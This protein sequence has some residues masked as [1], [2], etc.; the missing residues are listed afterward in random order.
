MAI[1]W[2]ISRYTLWKRSMRGC[3]RKKHMSA[4]EALLTMVMI[5]K[6]KEQ[7]NTGVNGEC[8]GPTWM[9]DWYDVYMRFLYIFS[10]N[11]NIYFYIRISTSYLN[12]W[13][14]VFGPNQLPMV[15]PSETPI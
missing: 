12:T 9:V 4:W 14:T 8:N 6:P 10:L 5:T 13:E 11:A 7:Y 2:A 15:L 1:F 3:A